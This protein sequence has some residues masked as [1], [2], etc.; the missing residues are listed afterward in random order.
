MSVFDQRGQHVTTQYNVSFGADYGDTASR[1]ELLTRLQAL[2]E[3]VGRAEEQGALDAES[4][5]DVRHEIGQAAQAARRPDATADAV[6]R[7]LGRGQAILAGI[8]SATGL[9]AALGSLIAALPGLF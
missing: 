8:S 3:E 7:R 9:A 5:A 1:E 2:A 6:G 4:A